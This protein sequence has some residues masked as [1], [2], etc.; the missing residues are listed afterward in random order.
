MGQHMRLEVRIDV[1]QPLQR[2][3][4]IKFNVFNEVW[5]HFKYEKLLGFCY[6][7][8][9]MGHTIRECEE[10]KGYRTD[11][12]RNK[13]RE[14]LKVDWL[15]KGKNEIRDRELLFSWKRGWGE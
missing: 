7:C 8:G 5:Y 2:G 4:K 3:I 6:H 11:V 14:W 1:T 15:K 10:E 12:G 13:Y 9:I